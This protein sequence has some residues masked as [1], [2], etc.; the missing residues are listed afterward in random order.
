MKKEMLK[1]T[2]KL[3]ADNLA[4]CVVLVGNLAVLYSLHILASKISI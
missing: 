3:I 1:L 4:L 2:H